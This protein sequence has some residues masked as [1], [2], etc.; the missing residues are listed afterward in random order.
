MLEHPSE[1]IG[2]EL[3]PGREGGEQEVGLQD[4]SRDEGAGGVGTNALI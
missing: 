2:V 4:G 3:R 1:M